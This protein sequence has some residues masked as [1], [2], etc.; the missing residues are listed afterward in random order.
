MLMQFLPSIACAG[1]RYPIKIKTI[2]TT[3]HAH[4]PHAIS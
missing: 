3:E 2:A 1:C 4:N